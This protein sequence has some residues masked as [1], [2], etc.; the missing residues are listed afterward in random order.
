MGKDDHD[1][2]GKDMLSRRGLLKGA[3]AAT[4]VTPLALSGG[5]LAQIAPAEP[6]APPPAITPPVQS[7][8]TTTT[9][10]RLEARE[11][12]TA[13]ERD[14]VE[15]IVARII[16][17]DELGPG[18]AE[19]RAAYYIDRALSGAL[20]SSRGA[21][22]S[23]LAAIDEYAL[24]TRGSV[25][26]A[27]SET[28]QDAILTEMQANTATGFFPNSASFFELIR[29]HTIQGTF[30]DPY[31]GGNADFIGWDL[32]GYPGARIF[33][34]EDDQRM[35]GAEPVRTSAHDNQM[36]S[37]TGTANGGGHDHHP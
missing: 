19:A 28:D 15:A 7:P 1:D 5:A 18:A 16:P 6:A 24:S 17:T 34:T 22:A 32:I 12:L 31:H 35:A 13:T 30:C 23:G 27:L 2:G 25:F 4:A 26:V 29:T 3:V 20:A 10:F 14:T 37:A 9:T 33:V 11:A 21:Y 36:F 8:S